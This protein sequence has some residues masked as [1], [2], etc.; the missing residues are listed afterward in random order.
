MHARMALKG[1]TRSACEERR[2]ALPSAHR[3]GTCRK[4]GLRTL[5]LERVR[6]GRIAFPSP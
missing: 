6:S 2:D 4:A 1:N 3:A 5:E